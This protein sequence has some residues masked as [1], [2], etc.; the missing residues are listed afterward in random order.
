MH[1]REN[2]WQNMSPIFSSGMLGNDENVPNMC[3]LIW[4]SLVTCV[5]WHWQCAYLAEKININCI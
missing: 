2:I 1:Q 5:N 3:S 4:R